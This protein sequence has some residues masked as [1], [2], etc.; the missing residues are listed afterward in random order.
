MNRIVFSGLVLAVT[1]SA[2]ACVQA[3]RPYRFQ[4]GQEELDRLGAQLQTAQNG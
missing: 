4:S 3:Q 2:T 1:L